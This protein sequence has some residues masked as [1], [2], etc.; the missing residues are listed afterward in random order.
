MNFLEAHSDMQ[1]KIAV[2]L[3]G[4]YGVGRAVT[5]ALANS[6]VEIAMCDSDDDGIADTRIQ[7][8]SLGG[9][10]FAMHA[11]VCSWEQLNAFYDEVE[12]RFGHIDIVVN[13]AGGV[14]RAALLDTTRDEN[15]RD[16]RLNFAYVM[17]SVRRSIPLIRKGGRGGSII[18]FTT[19]ECHRGAATFS[20]YSGA[21]AG[22]TNFSRAMAV[23]LGSEGIRV[24]T[25]VPDTTP[26]RASYGALSPADA[27][28]FAALP[29]DI[30]G[31]GV[32]MYVPQ[33]VNPSQEALG[34]AVLFLASKLSQ[35]ITG[36]SL[37]VDGGT[38]AAFG[39][40]DWPHGDG[41]LAA[42]PPGAIVRLFDPLETG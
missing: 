4:G 29:S 1:G 22:L 25:I 14:R 17:D 11:D 30:L 2:V 10:I 12:T 34:D 23:E 38:M 18:S 42:P 33:K 21:K 9:K 3:G 31:E 39:Y 15:A 36:V 26:A 41:Y 19:I 35:S 27:A 40:I 20:V 8:E 16:I 28:K 37:H 32:K 7:V 24:N 5:L 13:V 6:G